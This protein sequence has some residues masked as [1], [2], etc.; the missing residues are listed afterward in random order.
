MMLDKED[1]FVCRNMAMT[2]EQAANL[3]LQCR[4]KM[5]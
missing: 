1:I 2:D 5:I 4:L 3:A